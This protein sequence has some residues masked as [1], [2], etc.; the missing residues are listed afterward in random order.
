MR[1]IYTLTIFLGSALLFLVEPMVAKMIL[2]VFGGSASVWNAS[3]VFFQLMLLAGYWYAHASVKWLGPKVQPWVHMALLVIA[4]IVLPIGL[5]PGYAPDPQGLP[6]LQVVGLL[7]V[8]AGLPF[9]VIS[10]QAPLLQRWFAHTLDPRAHDPYF[11]YS[12]SNLG[13]ML[14]LLAYPSLVETT[15]DLKQQSQMWTLGYVLLAA[16]TLGS[17][18]MMLKGHPSSKLPDEQEA[19]IEIAEGPSNRERLRWLLLAAVP[20]SLMLGITGYLTTNIAPFPLL[21]VVPLAL[22]LLTF[23]I[24]FNH[25]VK[26][27]GT[28]LG[29]IASILALPTALVLILDLWAPMVPLAT[30]HLTVFFMLALA[31]HSNLSEM[32]PSA[33]HLTEFYLWIAAGGVLGGIFNAFFAPQVFNG[34]LEY[35][36]ALTT[37]IFLLQNPLREKTHLSR[38]EWVAAVWVVA[39]ILIVC[40]AGEPVLA[41]VRQSWGDTM[42]SAVAMA[43]I[44]ALIIAC[45]FAIDRRVLYGTALGAVMI[46][47]VMLKPETSTIIYQGRDFYGEKRVF[48]M[49]NGLVH[50]LR[51]GSTLHGSQNLAPEWRRKPITYYGANGPI[52]QLLTYF[53]GPRA[54]RAMAV[55][56]L[57]TGTVAAY[58]EPGQTIT[59][60]EIDPQVIQIATNPKLFTYIADSAAKVNI[61]QGD[62]RIEL[63]KAP[64][65]SYGIIILDAFS[66]DAVPLHLL[67][68]EAVQLYLS[69]LEPGGVIAFHTSNRYLA[70]PPVVSRIASSMGLPTMYREGEL[71]RNEE[72]QGYVESHWVLLARDKEDFGPLGHSILWTDTSRVKPGPIWT[73][74]FSNVVSALEIMD[75]PE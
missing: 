75:T 26:L 73:D 69:K 64:P 58:G 7:L 53:H 13:S 28:L 1:A 12:A 66:S 74:R 44:C 19:P 16:L 57:G 2:P 33:G 72:E 23:I 27:K 20:S 32:R 52:G 14:A 56:G 50:D 48:S 68:K 47:G 10:A 49:N 45:F 43:M 42:Q 4:L 39:A 34:L 9:F 61:V 36:I 8:M 11:L 29:R 22:Y 3:V 5:R 67:T 37:A 70:I 17:A 38:R 71:R 25:R 31:C 55:V 24:A 18:A 41:R 59:Y 30:L 35:P 54:K 6:P 63:A 15:L 65:Q 60:Y 40:F 51:H 62:A 46:F 21:W